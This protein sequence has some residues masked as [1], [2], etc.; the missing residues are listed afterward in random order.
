MHRMTPNFHAV[1]YS[2]DARVLRI[3]MPM[4]VVRVSYLWGLRL[5]DYEPLV[6]TQSLRPWPDG[7]DDLLLSSR[8]GDG[9]GDGDFDLGDGVRRLGLV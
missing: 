6:G 5:S 3:P 2:F 4:A 9:S 7:Y 1:L 8:D